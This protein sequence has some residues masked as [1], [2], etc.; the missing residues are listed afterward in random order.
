MRDRREVPPPPRLS[1]MRVMPPPPGAPSALGVT[2]PPR[3]KRSREEAERTARRRGTVAM[4]LDVARRLERR[5]RGALRRRRHHLRRTD[6]STRREGE[7]EMALG[8]FGRPGGRVLFPPI[9]AVSRPIVTL[10]IGWRRSG[11]LVVGANMPAPKSD[12]GSSWP[13]QKK[14]KKLDLDPYFRSFYYLCLLKYL[15]LS[16]FNQRENCSG[17]KKL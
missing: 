7:R 15:F 10:A 9:S 5:R 2:P 14:K 3:R 1:P 8:F 12:F 16:N 6:R 11:W 4:P 13:K 17:S